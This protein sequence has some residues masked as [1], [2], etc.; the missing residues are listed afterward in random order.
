MSLF[1]D[2]LKSPSQNHFSSIVP[3]A[4]SNFSKNIIVV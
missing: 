1:I 4:G 3:N 2:I